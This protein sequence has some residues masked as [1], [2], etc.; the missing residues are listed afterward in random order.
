MNFEKRMSKFENEAKNRK[1]HQHV[2][3][4]DKIATKTSTFK[5]NEELKGSYGNRSLNEVQSTQI[6][7]Y[8]TPKQTII[9]GKHLISNISE[10][11]R[12][13]FLSNTHKNSENFLQRDKKLTVASSV[14]SP[15]SL[16]LRII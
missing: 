7:S 8:K 13:S 11:T 1:L 9:S 14:H 15:V 3:S 16:W 4:M 12:I 10:M 5:L 6:Y 2:E